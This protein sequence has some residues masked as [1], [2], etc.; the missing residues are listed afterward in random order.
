M[1]ELCQA[2]GHA[3]TNPQRLGI[4]RNTLA[5][6]DYCFYEQ[7]ADFVI[8]TEDDFVVSTD[9]LEYFSWAAQFWRR[10]SG[11]IAVSAFRHRAPLVGSLRAAGPARGFQGQVWGTWR[12]RWEEAIRPLWSQS[13]HW[14]LALIEEA[15]SRGWA[16]VAPDISRSQHIGAVGQSMWPGLHERSRSWCFVPDIPPQEYQARS[17]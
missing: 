13:G 2:A 4:A 6:L 1:L 15:R 8:H 16:T 9:V 7:L 3:T 14:D 17:D 11:V 10:D 5:T 12:S